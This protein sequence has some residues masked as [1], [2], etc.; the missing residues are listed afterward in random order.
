MFSSKHII[1]ANSVLMMVASTVAVLAAGVALVD[2]VIFRRHDLQPLILVIFVIGISQV[3]QNLVIYQAVMRLT[4]SARDSAAPE[5]ESRGRA[6]RKL[7]QL[8]C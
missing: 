6:P 2:E 5:E 3:V 8:K 7:D 1:V 4:K